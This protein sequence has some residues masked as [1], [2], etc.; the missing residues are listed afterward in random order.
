[1]FPQQSP[2]FDSLRAIWT[3]QEYN[4]LAMSQAEIIGTGSMRQELFA[5][6][7]LSVHVILLILRLLGPMMNRVFALGICEMA[8]VETTEVNGAPVQTFIAY[9]LSSSDNQPS[10]ATIWLHN[11][12]Y[13]E[14]GMGV[15][16]W[17]GF[18]I[19]PQAHSGI[20][21]PKTILTNKDDVR[22]TSHVTQSHRV[23]PPM[24]T[25]SSWTTSHSATG[26]TY[27]ASDTPY[28]ANSRMVSA[29]PSTGGFDSGLSSPSYHSPH[30]HPM[31]R[32]SSIDSFHG[33]M[34][35][36]PAKDDKDDRGR[37]ISVGSS[38]PQVCA[39]CDICQAVVLKKS[40][41]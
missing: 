3:S 13:E 17:S 22:T 18:G 2:T 41:R 15:S 36:I 9:C 26:S 24:L 31:S 33:K 21:A 19:D 27:S 29:E 8:K 34:L 12:R 25:F 40:L 28:S 30:S 10:N 16:H 7:N 23:Q 4:D 32:L 11:D 20:L 39:Q 38:S 37:S 1:M 5:A 6:G 14:T 35:R